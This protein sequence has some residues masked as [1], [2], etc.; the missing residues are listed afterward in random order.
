MRA[1][2]VGNGPSLAN[3][4]LD[5]LVG[6]VTFAVT[7]IHLI[8]P[9]TTWRTNN[10]VW[11]EE[12]NDAAWIEAVGHH[13]GLGVRVWMPQ[14]RRGAYTNRRM[15][16]YEVPATT[17]EFYPM[18]EDEPTPCDQWHL[19]MICRRG[20][21][22]LSAIQIAILQGY[23]PL[24]LI[25]TDLGYSSKGSHFCKEYAD[26]IDLRPPKEMNDSLLAAH[27]IAKKCSPVPIYNATTGGKLEVYPRV[28]Y[29][30]LF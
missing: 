18:C 28:K 24:Y 15:R 7:R 10:F 5:K 1:F 23:S 30:D 3:T 2:I 25:G 12:Y 11:A 4:D 14:G 22:L 21:S 26:G 29:N 13:L 9:K 6:E 27:E 17:T 20:G 19:P 8:Y 16:K